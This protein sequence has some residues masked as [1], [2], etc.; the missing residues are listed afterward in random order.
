MTHASKKIQ[1]LDEQIILLPSQKSRVGMLGTILDDLAVI[2]E[3]FT[4]IESNGTR[5]SKFHCKRI[6]SNGEAES[7]PWLLFLA[8]KKRIFCYYCKLF[9]SGYP[10]VQH[11][12]PLLSTACIRNSLLNQGGAWPEM[13]Y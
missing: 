11:S 1:N 7:H 13:R 5:F 4:R 9:G 2:T 8:W 6:T 10:L 12:I 3:V